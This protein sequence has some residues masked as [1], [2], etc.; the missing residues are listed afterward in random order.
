[1]AKFC[2]ICPR[3]CCYTTLA[4]ATNNAASAFANAHAVLARIR[5]MVSH[6]CCWAALAI[7]TNNAAS[8][9][10]NA[11]ATFVRSC[12][13]NMPDRGV[14]ALVNASNSVSSY[15]PAFADAHAVSEV[16][17]AEF[18]WATRYCSR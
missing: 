15:W 8:V 4:K 12:A 9:F 16:L 2:T 6:P 7:A 5:A 1:M 17:R 10:A 3:I 11:H 18:A 14:A 13:L